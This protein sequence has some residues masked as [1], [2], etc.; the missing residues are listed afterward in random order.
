VP[1]D[2][3]TVVLPNPPGADG[4]PAGRLTVEVRTVARRVPDTI[5]LVVGGARE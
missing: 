2:A 5:R 3:V 1:G 4:D